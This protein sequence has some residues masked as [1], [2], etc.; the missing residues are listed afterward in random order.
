MTKVQLV[1]LE[2]VTISSGVGRDR[3]DVESTK[4]HILGQDSLVFC[5]SAD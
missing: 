1:R 5:R 3:F 2:L 4:Y